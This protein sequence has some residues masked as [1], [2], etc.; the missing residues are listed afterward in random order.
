MSPRERGPSTLMPEGSKEAA[1]QG[2][3]QSYRYF[4]AREYSC[5]AQKNPSYSMRAFARD[6]GVA[7][8]RI[9]E[10]MSAK[11]GISLVQGTAI[12]NRLPLT[13]QEKEI[14]LAFVS[15]YHSRAAMVRSEARKK[16]AELL[17]DK[18]LL[19]PLR[20]APPKDDLLG[21]EFLDEPYK[22]HHK[23]LKNA[24]Q[25]LALSDLEN[26]H[27]ASV[28]MRISRDKIN[29]LPSLVREIQDLVSQ[30]LNSVSTEEG[31]SYVF[32]IQFFP[33]SWENS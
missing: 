10:I 15:A 27:F 3:I 30:R 14:F 32:N 22:T 12:A 33:M 24:E 9:S 16:L 4:L 28:M 1:I 17:G 8:S 2:K 31:Q 29:E 6:I 25:A 20:F 23:M 21:T 11:R 26:C 7:P 19:S 5:R 13:D 18:S